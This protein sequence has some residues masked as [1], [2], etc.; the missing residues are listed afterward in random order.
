M[1]RFGFKIQTR[2]FMVAACMLHGCYASLTSVSNPDEESPVFSKRIFD[3]FNVILDFKITQKFTFS[4]H[5]IVKLN[6]IDVF[7]WIFCDEM[8]LNIRSFTHEPQLVHLFTFTR[9]DLLRSQKTHLQLGSD[10]LQTWLLSA[11]TQWNRG[12]NYVK[13]KYIE[14][15]SILS[16]LLQNSMTVM[17]WKWINKIFHIYRGYVI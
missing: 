8:S 13:D 17:W 9:Q 11:G 5:D 12:R 15:L 10:H 3:H 16:T 1:N 7:F 4:Y 6:Q 2:G 14:R